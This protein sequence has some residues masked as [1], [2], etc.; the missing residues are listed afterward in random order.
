[1][2]CKECLSDIPDDSKRCSHCGAIVG[3]GIKERIVRQVL[4]NVG[5][6]LM[7]ISVFV[8]LAFLLGARCK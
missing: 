6:I 2:K 3:A 7:L 1:M 5:V 4:V 8:I